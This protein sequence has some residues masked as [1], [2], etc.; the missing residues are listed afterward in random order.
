MRR[1]I[2]TTRVCRSDV[3][4]EKIGRSVHRSLH[5]QHR[6]LSARLVSCWI[7]TK[8]TVANLPVGSAATR[9]DA[10]Q[11]TEEGYYSVLQERGVSRSWLFLCMGATV[12]VWPTARRW[13]LPLPVT[14][15]P[16]RYRCNV[17]PLLV[18]SW[19]RCSADGKLPTPEEYQTCGAG[20]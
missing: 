18:W 7:T 13:F 8:A 9:M 20:G 5:D 12:R 2:R 3:Q 14:S 11:L 16:F 10:A 19:R 15:E 6:P 4:G 1:T 17:F